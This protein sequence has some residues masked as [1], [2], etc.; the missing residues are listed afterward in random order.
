MDRRFSRTALLLGDQSVGRLE[1]VRVAVFGM[2]GVGAY[3]A[4]SL[5]RSGVGYIR[6]VDFD[7]VKLSNCNRQILALESTVGMLKTDVA[8]NRLKDINPLCEVDRRVEFVDEKSA[9]RLL[10]GIE[11]VVD[12][13][14]SV[15]SKVSLLAHA[16]MMNIPTVT[17]MGSARKTDPFLIRSGD[18]SESCN[19]PLA[20]II[21]KRLHRRN[22]FEGIRCVYSIE[23][24]EKCSDTENELDSEETFSRG[25]ERA[26]LGSI[27]Y[28]T[29]IF[30]L[31]A[32]RELIDLILK[33]HSETKCEDERSL[34]GAQS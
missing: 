18:I 4:E 3:T 12:A 9:P 10:D 26:P 32:A 23:P 25:R 13:I 19:C 5:V 31:V 8:Y 29:G 28:M 20:K 21:R 33:P 34:S 11:F 14:D 17:S 15:S 6:I 1:A 7:M 30:G 22:I 27:S 24:V 16:R 2:G